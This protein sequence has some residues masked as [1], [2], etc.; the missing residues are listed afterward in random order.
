VIVPIFESSS[1]LNW[2]RGEEEDVVDLCL[3]SATASD[4]KLVID[5]SNL[6]DRYIFCSIYPTA[7]KYNP[8]TKYGARIESYA[9]V[10]K[11]RAG[12]DRRLSKVRRRNRYLALRCVGAV[13]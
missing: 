11:S 5:L 8:N 6:I 13:L 2:I 3:L 10:D 12:Q 9:E 7:V 1:W 4:R